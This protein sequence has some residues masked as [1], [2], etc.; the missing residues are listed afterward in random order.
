MQNSEPNLPEGLSFVCPLKWDELEGT[1]DKR[2][3]GK[4]KC[5]VQNIGG[6]SDEQTEALRDRVRAGERVCIAIPR[7]PRANTIR[8]AALACAASL[9]MAGCSK[10]T[11]TQDFQTFLESTKTARTTTQCIDQASINAVERKRLDSIYQLNIAEKAAGVDVGG[12][13]AAKPFPSAIGNELGYVVSATKEQPDLSSD[14]VE[15]SIQIN[16]GVVCDPTAVKVAS[17][18]HPDSASSSL[19]DLQSRCASASEDLANRSQNTA[20]FNYWG[21]LPSR[22][23]KWTFSIYRMLQESHPTSRKS[24]DELLLK[25][26]CLTDESK[27]MRLRLRNWLSPSAT[28][29]MKIAKDLGPSLPAKDRLKLPALLMQNL[30]FFYEIYQWAVLTS[31]HDLLTEKYGPVIDRSQWFA[32]NAEFEKLHKQWLTLASRFINNQLEASDKCQGSRESF[33]QL[34]QAYRVW[35]LDTQIQKQIP[36]SQIAMRFKAL[37]PKLETYNK[38]NCM[39]CL[40][41]QSQRDDYK[42]DKDF[43]MDAIQELLISEVRH[44]LKTAY[45]GSCTTLQDRSQLGYP[46]PDIASSSRPPVMLWNI[47]PYAQEQVHWTE[48]ASALI[49]CPPKYMYEERYAI[50]Q[51]LQLAKRGEATEQA[52]WHKLIEKKVRGD[53]AY[54]L[55]MAQKTAA[56]DKGTSTASLIAAKQLKNLTPETK[57]W[58]DNQSL[59]QKR[60]KQKDI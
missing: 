49:T 44:S 58:L 60:T 11:V 7:K 9:T 17:Y 1:G 8:I 52:H 20:A 23:H 3:C 50:E 51:L 10:Q 21:T 29:A 30:S 24:Y 31:V 36:W 48:L 25:L 56:K 4:C 22:N 38:A 19:Y 33:E 6:L 53:Y 12:M 34:Q 27:R 43:G 2:F 13:F 18:K 16:Q 55:D 14:E 42:T 41:A 28:Y 26:N 39:E 40:L 45:T 54:Y 37:A 15:L 46:S 47:S 32:D 5:T 35:I 57:H 59:S